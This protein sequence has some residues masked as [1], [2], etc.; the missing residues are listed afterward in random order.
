[1]AYIHIGF[2][3]GLFELENIKKQAMNALHV[4]DRYWKEVIQVS[5][6]KNDIKVQSIK[7]DFSC[8][9]N[10]KFL[11]TISVSLLTVSFTNCFQIG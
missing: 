11:P 9:E 8:F 6:W 1:M 2:N 3:K 5:T 7:P 10:S 4:I